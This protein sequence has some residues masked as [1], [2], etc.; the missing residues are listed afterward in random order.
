[1]YVSTYVFLPVEMTGKQ[2][3]PIVRGKQSKEKSERAIK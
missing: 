2:L 1:M 3:L